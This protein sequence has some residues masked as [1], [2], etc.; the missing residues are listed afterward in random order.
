MAS[1]PM[2]PPPA[3]PAPPP[4]MPSPPGAPHHEAPSP[5]PRT[6]VL[7][8]SH[9]HP[10]S[11]GPAAARQRQWWS[12]PSERECGSSVEEV[13]IV[14]HRCSIVVDAHINAALRA[15]GWSPHHDRVAEP[16]LIPFL[17]RFRS[18]PCHRIAGLCL[19]LFLIRLYKVCTR[20]QLVTPPPP[21][22]HR[23]HRTREFRADLGPARKSAYGTL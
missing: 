14:S 2:Y 18:P 15:V 11:A 5:P 4:L 13:L 20:P 17:L 22:R 8:R 6:P 1:A 9:P 10:G 12:A 19:I 23:R 3:P 21:R 7:P 16:C